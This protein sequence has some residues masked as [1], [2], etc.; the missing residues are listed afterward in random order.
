MTEE[1]VFP[2]HQGLPG[3]PQPPS[4]D[5]FCEW[6]VWHPASPDSAHPEIETG[7]TGAARVTYGGASGFPVVSFQGLRHSSQ[8]TVYLSFVVRLDK[9]FDDKDAI[10]IVFQQDFSTAAHS[11]N[12]RR[13]II[14]PVVEGVGAGGGAADYS[15]TAGAETIEV[16]TDRS[17]N[18]EFS[19]WD[20]AAGGGAGG[21]VTIPNVSNY[22]CR[23]RSWKKT[24]TGLGDDYN[25]S[26]EIELPSKAA[27]GGAD[28]I[29][30]TT[31]GFGF[32]YNV[33]RFSTPPSTVAFSMV[34]EFSWPPGHVIT[35]ADGG[36][37]ASISD[38]KI[39][40]ARMG[41]VMLTG[42]GT[43][44][45]FDGGWSSIGVG[46]ESLGSHTIDATTGVINS[47]YARLTNDGAAAPGVRAE[48]RV[49]DFG[50]ASGRPADWTRIDP[51][52]SGT[53]PGP[54]NTN[55]TPRTDIPAG[56]AATLR[57]NWQLSSADQ[58][59]YTGHTHQ[60]IWALL[61][62]DKDAKF[63][64]SSYRVN[65]DFANLSSS[66]RPISVNA[67]GYG[68]PAAASA[69]NNVVLFTSTRLL[70][71]TEAY[72]GWRPNDHGGAPVEGA[73][74]RVHGLARAIYRRW[75]ELQQPA[76]TWLSV[77][78]AYRNSGARLTIAGKQYPVYEV[79]DSYSHV[80]THAGVPERLRKSLFGEG[81]KYRG[82]GIFEVDAPAKTPVVL[83]TR[84]AA[85]DL[86]EH[87]VT[88]R[89]LTQIDRNQ[90]VLERLSR[91]GDVVAEVATSVSTLSTFARKM[92][93]AAE[94]VRPLGN[95]AQ[96]VTRVQALG[97]AL[98]SYGEQLAEL[99]RHVTVLGHTLDRFTRIDRDRFYASV[100]RVG[101]KRGTADKLWMQ[102]EELEYDADD[103][104]ALVP[105][106]RRTADRLEALHRTV[107]VVE[108]L[109]EPMRGLL[110][111]TKPPF[112]GALALTPAIVLRLRALESPAA[113]FARGLVQFGALRDEEASVRNSVDAFSARVS[114]R[115]LRSLNAALEQ[116]R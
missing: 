6:E 35:D 46:D 107:S 61:D 89:V 28:W 14:R 29:N 57:M 24:G 105:S 70:S 75:A 64:E 44:V 55:P 15:I 66:R 104:D 10:Y 20:P 87:P 84:H 110:R 94:S 30:L 92:R 77:T 54:N 51:R 12:T 19:K 31:A 88:E 56:G 112:V 26:I 93:W 48:F 11:A 58:T 52:A 16:R 36:P 90:S 109:S 13:L 69:L 27:G 108:T 82:P 37:F 42:T 63:A 23:S 74:R 32:Y 114:A 1:I 68:R 65:M 101:G 50:I 21:W 73:S 9:A 113:E 2:P 106:L 91:T 67:R 76:V 116:Y 60:C 72:D 25:W 7:W 99:E 38:I 96:Q 4:V 62:S 86:N 111:L 17:V 83:R 95:L 33:F 71:S 45:R 47:F 43:G 5:G 53:N 39:P 8:D 41:K 40:P 103:L 22:K 78:S 3:F 100:A 102:M 80:L 97:A 98:R 79:M 85:I 81:L 18:E 115:A 49:A 59:K 34:T